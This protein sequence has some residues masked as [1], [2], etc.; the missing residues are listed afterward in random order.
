MPEG[1][2]EQDVA[3]E[4]KEWEGDGEL[5]EQLSDKLIETQSREDMLA[6]V[7]QYLQERG[8]MA[9]KSAGIKKDWKANLK[10]EREE[11]K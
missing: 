7:R 2:A 4:E 8:D 5:G 11:T 3:P 10:I 9:V 6:A 1:E